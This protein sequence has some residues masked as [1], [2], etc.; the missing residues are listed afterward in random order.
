MKTAHFIAKILLAVLVPLSILA[1]PL[2]ADERRNNHRSESRHPISLDY[3]VNRARN[4]Y[5]G[6][7][8][9][10][11]TVRADNGPTHNVRILT[12]DGRVRRLRFDSS[13]GEYIKPP[14]R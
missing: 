10:A 7:V 3:A 12:N 8:I 13:T 4:E 5:N 1:Q 6:R 14:R 11:E 2:L 9:S